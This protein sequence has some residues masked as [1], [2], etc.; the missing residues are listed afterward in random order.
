MASST[1]YDLTS[2][3]GGYLD[4]HLI[5]PML[6]FLSEKM[7][8]DEQEMLEARLKLLSKTNMVDF[9][10]DVFG[11]LHP[12]LE[13][14]DLIKKRQSVLEELDRFNDIIQPVLNIISQTEVQEHIT[15]SRQDHAQFEALLSRHGFKLDMIKPLYDFAKF[16]YECGKYPEADDY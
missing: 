15:S 9:A 1:N 14:E 10:I 2:V 3:V 8:Y 13:P 16:Q 11:Q 4:R 6:E 7:V 5:F 12:G